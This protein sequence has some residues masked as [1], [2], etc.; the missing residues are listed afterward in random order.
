MSWRPYSYR[1]RMANGECIANVLCIL[2]VLSARSNV[3]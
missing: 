2:R 1:D 3:E